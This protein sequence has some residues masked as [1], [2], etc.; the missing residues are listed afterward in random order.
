MQRILK[1]TGETKKIF[2]TKTQLELIGW[3]NVSEATKDDLNDTLR[4]YEINTPERIAHFV[5]QITKESD[6]GKTNVEGGG[7]DPIEYFSIK[8]YGIKYRGVG[9]MQMTWKYNYQV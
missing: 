9:Y 6:Y 3:E 2:V 7:S 8:K 1:G 4:R 5:S